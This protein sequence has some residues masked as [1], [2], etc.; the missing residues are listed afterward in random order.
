MKKSRGPQKKPSIVLSSQ[1]KNE[2][3][4]KKRKLGHEALVQQPLL[5][6]S[7]EELI[8]KNKELQV[9]NDALRCSLEPR[10]AAKE[11]ELKEKIVFERQLAAV[12]SREAHD[13]RHKLRE[14]DEEMAKER[15]ALQ[16]DAKKANI[17]YDAATE[18]ERLLSSSLQELKVKTY[19]VFEMANALGCFSEDVQVL[20]EDNQS[21]LER[22]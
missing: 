12:A 3:L 2:R 5:L 14:R 15:R 7:N 11:Q 21:I 4:K 10:H 1:E 13:L 16:I 17:M 8:K 20:E 19:L 9:S 18:K 6:A 22:L